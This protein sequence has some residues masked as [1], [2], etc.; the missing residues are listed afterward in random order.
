MGAGNH[1]PAFYDDPRLFD[2]TAEREPHM[3]FGGGV[4][5]CLGAS[6]ARAEMQ[7]ALP[8]LAT[9][10]PDLKLAG[11]PTWR[12]PTGIYGPETLPVSFTAT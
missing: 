12:P 2:I 10:M 1:D 9:A 11:E 6:L 4:H 7:E 8:I 5:Y 3:T